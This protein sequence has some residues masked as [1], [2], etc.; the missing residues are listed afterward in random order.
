MRLRR[1]TDVVLSSGSEGALTIERA[2]ALSDTVNRLVENMNCKLLPVKSSDNM[3]ALMWAK[4]QLNLGNSVN[5]LADIPVKAMLEQ[6]FY[7]KVIAALMDE[8]LAVTDVKGITLP[9][10][11]ALPSHWIP[12]VLRLPDWLFKLV[13][14][15][16][17]AIDPNVRTSMW[18]D[19]SQGKRT[20]IEHLNGA[21]VAN[22]KDLNV[23]CSA[24]QKVIKLVKE[25]ENNQISVKMRSISAS[26]LY[27]EVIGH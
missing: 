18:W 23:I 27:K 25:R 20:E 12:K 15:N 9:K 11:T 19:L 4:L 3:S 5:A 2:L 7:R 26:Q 22:A 14:N 21:I 1:R 24:N 13:A 6:R 17:L 10:V 16:M 8:L